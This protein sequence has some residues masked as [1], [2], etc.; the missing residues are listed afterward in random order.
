[1]GEAAMLGAAKTPN[2]HLVEGRNLISKELEM[3]LLSVAVARRFVYSV[4][5]SARAAFL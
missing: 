1:M 2:K 3:V 5:S 4:Y